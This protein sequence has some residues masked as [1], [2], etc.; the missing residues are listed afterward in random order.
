MSWEPVGVAAFA[1]ALPV[2]ALAMAIPMAIQFRLL[3]RV[4]TPRLPAALDRRVVLVGT[5][6]GAWLSLLSA[7]GSGLLFI[8]LMASF[9]AAKRCP[10]APGAV[11]LVALVLVFLKS[12]V[13][14]RTARRL[15]VDD[16]G[17]TLGEKRRARRVR[18]VHVTELR[19]DQDVIRYRVNRALVRGADRR[20]WDGAIRNG[21]GVDTR[22]LLRLLERYRERAMDK[23]PHYLTGRKEQ[24]PS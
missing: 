6:I 4:K 18:W 20:Y 24:S 10:P 14:A 8:A 19:A 11:I 13:D 12:Y 17:F 22:Q 9:V 1:I 23:A 16:E 21:W 2:G 15:E 5:T 7:I 3:S